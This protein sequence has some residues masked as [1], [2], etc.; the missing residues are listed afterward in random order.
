M[1]FEFSGRASQ[2]VCRLDNDLL[3]IRHFNIQDLLSNIGF[4]LYMCACVCVYIYDKSAHLCRHKR[5]HKYNTMMKS[6][7]RS[8]KINFLCHPLKQG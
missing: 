4:M 2:G 5:Q 8:S 6:I 3:D 1:L 7:E